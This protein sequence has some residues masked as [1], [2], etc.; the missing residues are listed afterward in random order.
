[1]LSSKPEVGH[2]PYSVMPGAVKAKITN[3]VVLVKC[4]EKCDGGKRCVSV[5][6][7]GQKSIVKA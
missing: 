3:V 6:K 7:L 1:M 2:P 5:S 4:E